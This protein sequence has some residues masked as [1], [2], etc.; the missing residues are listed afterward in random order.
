MTQLTQASEFLLSSWI[1]PINSPPLANACLAVENDRILAVVSKEEFESLPEKIRKERSRDLGESVIMPGLL[2][3]HTHLDY[4]ALK[5][6]DNYSPFF[7]WIRGL[8]ANSWQWT[9]EEWL[10]SALQGAEEVL[11]SGTSFIVDASY[12]GAAAHAVAVSGLRGIVGLEIFG[13]EEEGAGEAFTDWLGKY[14][15][16]L[17]ESA[18]ET[19]EAI[20]SG[21]LKVTIAPHTPYSVCPSLLRKA[22]SWSKDKNLPLLIHIA[23]S[24]AECR[25]IAK[26]DSDLDS[27]LEEA[28]RKKVPE[29]LSWKG[30]GLSP[31]KHLDSHDLLSENMLAAHLV[32]V[33]ES[34]IA[35]LA[36]KKVSAVHC[37][38]SNSRLRNGISPMSKIIDAGIRMGFGTDSAASGD[39]LNVRQEARFAWDLHRAVHKDFNLQAERAIHYLTLG[40]ACALNVENEIASLESGKKADFAVFS[41]EHL[42][43]LA[44]MR[45]Y[46][47]L[48]YGGAKLSELYVDGKKLVTN[49]CIK[50]RNLKPCLSN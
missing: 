12:S 39:D 32:Q 19:K 20:K 26:S 33:D 28:F 13:I 18:P 17:N 37:P 14:E 4:S 3:L 40:A 30:K 5:H 34:D 8:I 41:L 15:R 10:H 7:A 2:N 49:G 29:K 1:L 48:I 36:Q 6:F 23:E 42:P 38:R 27:F 47:S 16:F 25:W 21:R 11:L 24:E 50:S 22:V 43:A 35:I 44:K 31:V 46:E 45:P 9:K